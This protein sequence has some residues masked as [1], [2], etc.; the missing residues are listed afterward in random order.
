MGSR[1]PVPRHHPFRALAC[2]L[3]LSATVTASAQDLPNPEELGRYRLGPVRF[4][5]VVT[6]SQLGVDTNVFNEPDDPKQDF[7]A[8]FGPKVEFW[9]RA[10]RGLIS[11]ESGLEYFY[12]QSY[13]SQRSFGTLQRVRLDVRAGRLTPFGELNYLN[14]RQ[15]PG[16]EIDA[17][18]R[19]S[20]LA[21]LGGTDLRL[22]GRS[23]VRASVERESYRFESDD[24]F[25]EADLSEELDRDS[26]T[27]ALAWRHQLTPLTTFIVAGERQWDRFVYSTFRDADG[28][29]VTPGFEFKP[30]A[31]IDG[32]AFVG[33][34]WFETLASDVPDYSGVAA[35]A[36]LGY[37]LHATRIV[38]RIQRDVTYSFDEIQPYYV[39][40]DLSLTVTQRITQQW[41]VRGSVMKGTLDYEAVAVTTEN[42]DHVRQYGIGVGYRLGETARFGVDANHVTRDSDQPGRSYDG[43]RI[44]GTIEY[45]VRQR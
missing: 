11:G 13:D 9:M 29:K 25:I 38:G 8:A 26:V 18:A 21:G 43:W 5:P 42:V 34:R 27:A 4:T 6:I 15:R 45:G 2:C 23:V 7:T 14:T 32:S 37:S 31:L 10:G 35:S 33:Y 40:T 16:Y 36:D 30:F 12:F 28:V 24:S 39:L 20:Q 44:G 1:F 3:V 22:G 17:R 19:R 41:D